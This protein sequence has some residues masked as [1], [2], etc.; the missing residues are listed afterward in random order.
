MTD[1][2]H[3]LL[4]AFAAFERWQSEC[5]AAVSHQ[6]LSSTDNA[7][8]HIIRMKERPKTLTEVARLLARDDLSNLQYAIKKL[9]SAGLV[10]KSKEKKRRGVAYSVTDQG[11]QVTDD[12]ADLR[13]ALLIQML[14]EERDS[15]AQ[16]DSA[17][18]LL[19]LL[20]GVYDQAAV[21]VV[22]HSNPD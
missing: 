18:R 5:L 21:Y 1:L 3:T 15:S 19:N 13:R 12:Y 10:E 20:Q 16:F 9:T 2:E 22:S 4:R 17:R 6:P 8:L 7:V 14:P 11:R